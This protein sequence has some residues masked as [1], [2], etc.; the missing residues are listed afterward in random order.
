MMLIDA[1]VMKAVHENLP[2]ETTLTLDNLLSLPGISAMGNN[3]LDQSL[4]RIMKLHYHDLPQSE[5]FE[6]ARWISI[7]GKSF[8]LE[9]TR[10]AQLGS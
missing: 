7:G 2:T 3:N 5:K 8:R 10:L 9:E 6:W 1:N 4:N